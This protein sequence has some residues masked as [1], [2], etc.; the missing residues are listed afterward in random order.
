MK[1]VQIRSFFS[2]VFPRIQT[3][4]NTV[5]GHF[6]RT[7]NKNLTEQGV[8]YLFEIND[9]D[10][11]NPMGCVYLNDFVLA[12]V[13]QF[14]TDLILPFSTVMLTLSKKFSCKKSSFFIRQLETSTCFRHNSTFYF[15][16]YDPC[17]KQAIANFRMSLLA[18]IGFGI[19]KSH[20]KSQ[21]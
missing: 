13:F 2:S 20:C 12:S 11:S 15:K 5:F 21:V 10:P 8:Q 3:R 14:R 17:L 19:I 9:K 6:S 16:Q 4:K 1:S 18:L 7:V